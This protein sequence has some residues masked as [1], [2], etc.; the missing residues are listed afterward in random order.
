[1]SDVFQPSYLDRLYLNQPSDM[2]RIYIRPP[3]GAVEALLREVV[4][5]P[6]E[7]EFDYSPCPHGQD[8]GFQLNTGTVIA[9][10]AGRW[11]LHCNAGEDE[12]CPRQRGKELPI[13]QVKGLWT[14]SC[15]YRIRNEAV[16]KLHVGLRDSKEALLTL[17]ALD[18]ELQQTGAEAPA[19][20]ELA[21]AK[22]T[23]TLGRIREYVAD[24]EWAVW[25]NDP[26]V[27]PTNDM[28]GKGKGKEVQSRIRAV[29]E[30]YFPVPEDYDE[31]LL[32]PKESELL[33]LYPK[34][35]NGPA[36]EGKSGSH[37][38]V[39]VYR[40]A[41]RPALHVLCWMPG[42]YFDLG[43][44]DVEEWR[45][46][47]F[48]RFCVG[49]SKYEAAKGPVNMIGRGKYMIYLKKG[50]HY[51]D[52]HRL[53]TWE[54][55]ACESADADARTVASS[56][57]VEYSSSPDRLEAPPPNAVASSSKIAFASSSKR[58]AEVA[59]ESIAKK[60]KTHV[61]GSLHNP[62]SVPSSDP[63]ADTAEADTDSD[64]E[65]VAVK[66]VGLV[67]SSDEEM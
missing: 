7:S 8:H 45:E 61:P 35:K 51:S 49:T 16:N 13:T 23:Q 43:A 4:P 19:L 18:A 58:K 24:L 42:V 30:D 46:A 28:E 62:I 22:M 55:R 26:E 56:S 40:E 47:Q 66:E 20:P 27:L 11:E 33:I 36:L 25:P 52:C 44:Y 50:V 32:D 17:F 5:P 9:T 21:A 6:D 59:L 41:R 38:H 3:M 53:G 29:S 1:M 37:V 57:G 12:R 31:E 67:A 54:E 10:S 63:D 34:Q 39:T 60:V 48:L 64:V 15:D 14:L 2:S 65:I